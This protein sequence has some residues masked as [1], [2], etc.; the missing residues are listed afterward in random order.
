VPFIA[1]LLALF[2]AAAG[3]T[4]EGLLKFERAALQVGQ[5]AFFGFRLGG[6]LGECRREVGDAGLFLLRRRG[7]AV[8][9]IAA[10]AAK[11]PGKKPA[12]KAKAAK[13]AKSDDKEGAPK[14]AAKATKG[15]GSKKS[16]VAD[17]EAE[18]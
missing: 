10:R 8:E 6:G 9:R 14:A 18:T 15:R 5:R 7:E 17:A 3:A 4:V 2:L 11:G 13:A 12:R 1:V 16:T